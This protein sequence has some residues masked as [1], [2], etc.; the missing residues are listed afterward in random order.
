MI[1]IKEDEKLNV[2]NHSSA[3]LLAHAVKRLYPQAQFWVGPVIEDGFYYDMDLGDASISEEDFPKIEQM[4]RKISKE[5]KRITRVELTKEEALEEF[6]DDL[7]KLDLINRLGEDEVIS[8]YRQAEFIDL[9]RGPHVETTKK[10][11][12]F[13]LLKVSGAYWKGDANNQMLQRVYGITFETQEDLEK[14][15]AWLEAAKAR[16]HKKLGKELGLFMLSEYGPGMPFWLPNGMTLRHALEDVYRKMHLNRGYVFC[17]TPTMLSKELWEISGHWGNY[18]D[19]MYTST[20]EDRE[21][22]IK[23]M[24]CPGGMLVYKNGLHS[25][26]DLPMRL[27]EMGHVHR[28]EA[29]GALNG[30]FRVRSFTQD[31]AHLFMTQEQLQSEIIEIL[32][33]I[34]EIYSIFGLEYTIELST[35]PEA[36]YIGT[37]EI[38]DASEQALKDAM[39]A[40]GKPYKINPG[41]GAFYGPK[42]DFKVRDSLNRIW[43]CGTVQLDNNLPERF[44]L[45]YVDE[46]GEKKR[47]VMLHRAIFGSI[48]RFIGILIEHFGGAFP[49]WLSPLQVEVIP[50]NTEFHMDYANEVL[51]KLNAVGI[52][53]HVD[54]RNEKLGY[55]LREAQKNKTPLQLIIGEKEIEDKS[56]NLRRYGERDQ[57]S[58][59]LNE[60]VELALKEIKEKTIHQL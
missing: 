25:Y 54:G 13:K 18:K 15:E 24:N 19:N 58:M 32:D 48:E 50:V 14:Y 4:M 56:V 12:F 17:E 23:P 57:N 47:P 39:D 52:R 7:Y 5:D 35:R 53:A 22:A 3:H 41:D 51:E 2:L 37:V 42:L 45:V 11:K 8:A 40:A 26:R 10:I 30:L 33:F 9:C 38:W 6:K 16:D 36:N 31:D 28:Y 60:F 29:S 44:D 27:A 46:K 59:D 21:F 34:D 55:R 43:Q 49:V 1:N 20:I